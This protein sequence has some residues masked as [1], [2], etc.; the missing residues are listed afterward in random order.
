MDREQEQVLARLAQR[1]RE[2]LRQQKENAALARRR[3]EARRPSFPLVRVIHPDHGTLLLHAESKCDAIHTAA[4]VWK[5]PFLAIS[6]ETAVWAHQPNTKEG[7]T[8]N[9]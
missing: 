8:W 3:K 4:R 5:V 1:R 2:E 9:D 7:T 6:R